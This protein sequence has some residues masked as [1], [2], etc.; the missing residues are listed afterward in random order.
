MQQGHLSWMHSQLFSAI[1][2]S[3]NTFGEAHLEGQLQ[4]QASQV[5]SRAANWWGQQ[6]PS[7]RQARTLL[8]LPALGSLVLQWWQ[9]ALCWWRGLDTAVGQGTSSLSPSAP[10]LCPW[11]DRRLQ[12]RSLPPEMVQG[13]LAVLCQPT[14]P[15]LLGSPQLSWADACLSHGQSQGKTQA[16]GLGYFPET[17]SIFQLSWGRKMFDEASLPKVWN[18]I[19]LCWSE[20][21]KC[22]SVGSTKPWWLHSCSCCVLSGQTRVQVSSLR[23]PEVFKWDCGHPLSPPRKCHS[24]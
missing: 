18:W 23:I 14:P 15:I 10:E 21:L 11:E 7:F 19:C 16:T 8:V 24:S 17:D 5:I 20:I 6:N 22:S 12:R 1:L 4:A 13:L 3:Y 9:S 2:M